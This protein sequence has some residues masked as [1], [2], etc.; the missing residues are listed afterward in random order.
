MYTS[1][2]QGQANF[3]FWNQYF[4]FDVYR[5]LFLA[6]KKF[7]RVKITPQP[8]ANWYKI[9]LPSKIS[10]LPALFGKLWIHKVAR[11]FPDEKYVADYIGEGKWRWL[12]KHFRS[13]F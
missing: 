5:K 7:R 3:D 9:P 6:L 2:S 10:D 4:N 8:P 12:I 11:Y 13:N 1:S